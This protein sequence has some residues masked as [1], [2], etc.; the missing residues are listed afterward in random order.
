MDQFFKPYRSLTKFLP[1]VKFFDKELIFSAYWP[2]TKVC[3][4]DGNEVRTVVDLNQW[5]PVGL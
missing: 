1:C 2:D 5:C 3:R 4:F